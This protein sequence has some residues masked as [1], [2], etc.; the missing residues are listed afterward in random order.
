MVV[1]L[2]CH[3]NISEALS[4]FFSAHCVVLLFICFSLRQ[5]FTEFRDALIPMLFYFSFLETFCFSGRLVF[6][7][8]WRDGLGLPVSSAH[9]CS[10]LNKSRWK[11]ERLTVQWVRPGS[12]RQRGCTCFRS[13]WRSAG[14]TW[15]SSQTDLHWPSWRPSP[16][17]GQSKS[18][19]ALHLCNPNTHTFTWSATGSLQS[20]S[21]CCHRITELCQWRDGTADTLTT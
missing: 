9:S 5:V 2:L 10:K 6:T 15:S 19:L 18:L 17:P 12:R 11:S 8:S 7:N 3:G 21:L 16:H 20:A 4:V 13:G 1:P 14:S